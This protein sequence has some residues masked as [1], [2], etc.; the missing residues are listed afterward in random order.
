MIRLRDLYPAG[1][2]KSGVLKLDT[3]K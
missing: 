1:T 3:T 2:T